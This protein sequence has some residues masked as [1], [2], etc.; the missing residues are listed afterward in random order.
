MGV[1]L[2]TR[3][4]EFMIVDLTSTPGIMQQVWRHHIVTFFFFIYGKMVPVEKKKITRKQRGSGLLWPLVCI[5]SDLVKRFRTKV[6]AIKWAL[7]SSVVYGPWIHIQCVSLRIT[8]YRAKVWY[9]QSNLLRWYS[10]DS[11]YLQS[12]AYSETSRERNKNTSL[13]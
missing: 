13:L 11:R 1:Q 4:L 2:D 10:E 8:V 9:D 12:L 7:P 3:Y 6:E 5:N